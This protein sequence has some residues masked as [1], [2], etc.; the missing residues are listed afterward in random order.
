MML[1]SGSLKNIQTYSFNDKL[2]YDARKSLLNKREKIK[3]E[4][5]KTKLTNLEKNVWESDPIDFNPSVYQPRPPKRNSKEA[6]KPWLYD[7]YLLSIER[8]SFNKDEDFLLKNR[9]SKI[10]LFNE[11]NHHKNDKD[12]VKNFQSFFRAL[13]PNED[14]FKIAKTN[15]FIDLIGKYKNPVEHDFRGVC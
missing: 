2:N 3:I 13:S 10:E 9:L 12:I 4:R 14:R 7:K 6:I 11:F 15:G 8:A 1:E 5:V